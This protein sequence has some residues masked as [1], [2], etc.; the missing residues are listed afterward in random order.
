[1]AVA[2]YLEALKWQKEIIKIHTI[3][4]GKN[5]HPNY[6][7]GGMASR[8][9]HA[10]RQRH[11]H[12]APEL[13]EGPDPG[14][15]AAWSRTC[16]SPTCWRWRRSI[17]NGRR[18]AAASETT[19]CTATCRRTASATSSQFRFP[20]GVILNK[21]LS[22]VL[23]LDLTDPAQVQEE[24]AHSWYEYPEGKAALHPW[25]GV[26]EP[27]VHRA[28]AAVQATRRERPSTRG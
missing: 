19:W 28:Q 12:G 20:R 9:R 8:H 13:C 11:Q 25:D 3:F 6:L 16:T 17:R 15:H 27:Q 24:I 18:S 5:P 2:H 22:E 1:M 10:E 23:P 7:V 21:N 14:R 26:T 4:G